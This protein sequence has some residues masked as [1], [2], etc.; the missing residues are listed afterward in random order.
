MISRHKN[1]FFKLLKWNYEIVKSLM[2]E[3]VDVNAKDSDGWMARMPLIKDMLTVIYYLI[4]APRFFKIIRI[5]QQ[6]TWSIIMKQHPYHI[7]LMRIFY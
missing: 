1:S 4:M 2:F 3:G 7:I 5:K 6:K